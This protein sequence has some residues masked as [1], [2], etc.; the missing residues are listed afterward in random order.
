MAQHIQLQQILLHGVVFK[1]G[2][3]GVRRGVVR[4]VLHRA[5]VPNL[6]FLGND[7]QAAGVLAGG[8]ADPH[9]AGGQPVLLRP[10][11]GPAPL[12]QVLFYIAKGCFLRHGADGPGPEHVGLSKHLHTVGM[13]LGLVLPGEIQVNVRHLV[14]AEAQEGLKGDVE[15]VLIKGSPTLGT[16]RIRQVRPAAVALGHVEGGEFAVRIGAAVMGREGIDLCNTCHV[17]HNGRAHRTTG[18]HQIAMLQRVLHQ[19]LGGHV[20]HVIVAADDIPQL[21]LHPLG[22]EFRGILAV[23]QAFQ[24]LYRVLNRGGEQIVRD[25]PKGLAHVR[26][27]VGIAHHHFI[28]LLRT[29]V[30]KLLQHFI[31]GAKIQR[32][33]LI[34]VV[35][36]LGGQ[37]NMAVDLILRV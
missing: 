30:G 16:H 28:G 22:D 4:R 11:H 10:G 18:A 17:G 27:G 19:L 37:E 2:G 35:K 20:N 12:R 7:H 31:R 9:T 13:G 21:R 29:Q 24:I 33:G 1:M 25:R 5:E 8:P 3:N 26:N 32:I 15:A 34:T 14:A 36:S 23:H 6:V